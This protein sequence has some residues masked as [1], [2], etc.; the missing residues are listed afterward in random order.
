MFRVRAAALFLLVAPMSLHAQTVPV[1]AV[2][3]TEPVP[4]SGDA[5]DDPAIWIHP[6]DP[7]LS[8]IIGTDKQA[9]LAVYDLAGV[10]LQFIASGRP[11]NV[12]VRYDFPLDDELVD[13]VAVGNRTANTIDV[14]RVNPAT[15]QL[16]DVTAGPI[17]V[18]VNEPYGFALYRSCA[19]DNFYA[20]VNDPYG[21]VEQWRLFDNGA[22]LVTAELVRAFSVGLQTEGMAADDTFGQLYIAEEDVGIWRYG[23]EPNAGEDR[24]LVDETGMAGYL[25]ADVEGLTIYQT[26]AGGGYLLASSQGSAEFVIYTRHQN[27]YV[28][29]FEVVP[30]GDIDGVSG[31]DGIDVMSAA[32]GTAF[33]QGLFIVQDHWNPGG[34]QNFKLIAWEMIAS[35]G[36]EM[37]L[38]D[39]A[40]NP[41]AFSENCDVMPIPGDLDGDCD[42][43]QADLGILLAS[44]ELDDGGDLDGDDDTDQADLG[45]MLAN[46][47]AQC[48]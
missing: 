6:T 39:P 8:L 15:R 12:D 44:Y 43:D 17:S 4:S 9:G 40:W 14:Y 1:P 22:G 34:N 23:A 18:G 20:L 31:T 35:A 2:V 16:E 42:V 28:M 32:L 33:P 25:T 10:E 7:S 46:Y 26:S 48:P 47:D 13:I 45:I 19:T 36:G 37:L 21:H 24:V 41:R 38:I 11:N 27:T 30:F 29:T 3:E 5:A